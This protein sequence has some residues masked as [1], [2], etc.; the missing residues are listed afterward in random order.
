MR[1]FILLVQFVTTTNSTA[2]VA[3]SAATF[4]SAWIDILLYMYCSGFCFSS[5]IC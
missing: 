3:T 5:C 1:F 4:F 2:I